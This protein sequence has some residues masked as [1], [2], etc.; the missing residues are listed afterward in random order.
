M[1]RDRVFQ[2]IDMQDSPQKKFK[3]S[4]STLKPPRERIESRKQHIGEMYIHNAAAQTRNGSRREKS[5]R[6]DGELRLL[7]RDQL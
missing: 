1:V 5:V 6:E 3:R 2:Q 4:A 7:E